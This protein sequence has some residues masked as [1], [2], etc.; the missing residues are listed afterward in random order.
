[1]LSRSELN[2][3]VP[4]I[5]CGTL[6]AFRGLATCGRHLKALVQ[7]FRH[8]NMVNRKRPIAE[9]CNL[10]VVTSDPK[11]VGEGVYSARHKTKIYTAVDYLG[12]RLRIGDHVALYTGGKEWI[13]VLETLYRDPET[14]AAMLKGRWFWT[15]QDV[16]E[17]EGELRPN[18]RPSKC[19]S[20]ELIC[21]DNRDSNLVE[22]ISRK[23]P[24]LSY[25]NFLLVKKLV[26]RSDSPWKKTF[27]CD[28]QYY[29]K[30]HRFSEL[31][32]SL[33]PGD[34]IPQD[35]RRAAGLPDIQSTTMDNDLDY[36]DAYTEP[37]LPPQPRRN[38][39][40]QKVEQVDTAQ[41]NFLW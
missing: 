17:H 34:P 20:H 15:M 30:A 33:F 28:R 19:P 39:K 13:C 14:N 22:S 23:C 3:S 24:I 18:I 10:E 25:E 36:A 1:M 16:K 7:P 35:L 5:A 38:S 31:N 6:L 8:S 29:H 4:Q 27:Y 41:L 26:L 21:C 32:A 2:F 12:Q 37:D 9:A 11:L 40:S